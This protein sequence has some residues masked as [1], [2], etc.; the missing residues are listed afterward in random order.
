MNITI[1]AVGLRGDVFFNVTLANALIAEG[2]NAFIAST[3]DFAGLIEE[4][5]VPF[6]PIKINLREIYAHFGGQEIHMS[7]GSVLKLYRKM[8]EMAGPYAIQLLEECLA[9]CREADLIIS[10]PIALFPAYHIAEYLKIPLIY[11]FA[12][13]YAPTKQFPS[14]FQPFQ[15]ITLPFLNLLTH[16]IED[17]ILASFCRADAAS[18][19][20]RFALPK[21]A[22]NFSYRRMHG[23][24]I[25]TILS[26]SPQ[27]L[28]PPSDWKDKVWY[29]GYLLPK[30]KPIP[31]PTEIERFLSKGSPIYI[32]FGS[33]NNI[34]KKEHLEMV[35]SVLKQNNEQ[36]IFMI[37]GSQFEPGQYSSRLLL[38]PTCDHSL[39]FP[40]VKMIIHH[41]GASTLAASLITGKPTIIAPC[42][43][44]NFFWGVRAE[45]IGVGPRMIPFGKLNERK[46]QKAISAVNN[47]PRFA[48]RAQEISRE[49]AKENGASQAA[50]FIIRYAQNFSINE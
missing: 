33:M 46:L 15:R 8:R 23:R 19:R 37:G 7:A 10:S 2:H 17:R 40:R 36:A 22:R 11:A 1:L 25:P 4:Y 12:S 24:Y 48:Q 21:M 49:L 18:V 6:R 9:F 38:A 26:L 32:G 44:D 5:N 13:P 28:P 16:R 20:E 41:G 30:E 29:F 42:A 31:L 27:V 14:V 50:A 47:T 43:F 45:R 34:L 3:Q 39:L 35:D